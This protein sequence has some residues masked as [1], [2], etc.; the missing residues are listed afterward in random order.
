[1]TRLALF[2]AVK[3]GTCTPLPLLL[4]PP[5]RGA[6]GQPRAG[7]CTRVTS[8][9][10]LPLRPSAG[11]PLSCTQTSHT[12]FPRGRCAEHAAHTTH[13]HMRQWCRRRRS[14]NCAW[15]ACRTH[16][17]DSATA[18]LQPRRSRARRRS[19]VHGTHRTRRRRL[20][21]NPVRVPVRQPLPQ[22]RPEPVARLQPR[23]QR[24][25]TALHLPCLPCR[26]TRRAARARPRAP[27][28]QR[29]LRE[30]P[31]ALE[32]PLRLRPARPSAPRLPLAG[33]RLPGPPAG[34]LPG[35]GTTLQPW[36]ARSVPSRRR[37]Q[38]GERAP[39]EERGAWR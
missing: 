27:A 19:R 10:L 28:V 13:P 11:P 1:M 17:R 30:L 37:M 20:V 26:P 3:S 14:E 36:P 29:P 24:H 2:S 7:R 21:R 39:K 34:D 15:H 6:P 4:P 22:P 38:C 8:V 9:L 23:L 32:L 31:S 18:T 5:P 16:G 35:A 33:L 25:E 12:R